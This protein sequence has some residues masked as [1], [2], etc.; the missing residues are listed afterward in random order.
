MYLLDIKSHKSQY[1]I[2]QSQ[3]RIHQRPQMDRWH[4]INTDRRALGSQSWT[5]FG[6]TLDLFLK[7][8]KTYKF[9]SGG[10]LL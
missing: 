5:F 9:Y 1:N 4:T 8:G 7:Q 6:E 10:K 2:N 3:C